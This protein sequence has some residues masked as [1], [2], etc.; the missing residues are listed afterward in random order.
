MTSKRI[1]VIDDHAVVRWGYRALLER[2]GDLT[3]VGEA[4]SGEEALAQVPA[5][6]LDLVI[7]DVSLGR[8]IDGIETVERL[9]RERPELPALVISLHSEARLIERALRVGAQ[10]YVVK[11]EAPRTLVQAVRHVLGGGVYLSDALR[12]RLNGDRLNGDGLSNAA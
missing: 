8:G 5:L 10:G 6:E 7:A 12:D 1:Y 2:E 3:I 9:K 4:A 11:D